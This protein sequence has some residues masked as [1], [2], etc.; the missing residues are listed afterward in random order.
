MKNKTETAK[1]GKSTQVVGNTG[2]YYACYR[3]S[4]LGLNVMPTARN[5][6]GIDVLAYTPDGKK[7]IGIQVKSLSKK[8]AVPLGKK[9]DDEYEPM[10]DYWIVVVLNEKPD[11]YI[12]KPKEVSEGVEKD[13]KGNHWL[14]YKAYAKKKYHEAWKRIKL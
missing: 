1:E 12:L 4:Q 8:W 5:A 2:M 13:S 6:K 7:Y 9:N 3:L 11:C 10:G 14:G